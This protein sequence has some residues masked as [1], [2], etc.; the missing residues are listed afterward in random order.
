VGANGRERGQQH[1]AYRGFYW[2]YEDQNSGAYD[3]N[4]VQVK[5]TLTLNG[6]FKLECT[7]EGAGQQCIWDKVNDVA[8]AHYDEINRWYAVPRYSPTSKTVYV[9]TPEPATLTLLTLGGL[10]ILR[11]RR[12]R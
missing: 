1:R 11:R 7:A 8:L 9:A 4:D 6:D 2:G 10:A 3:F 5:Q 12:K